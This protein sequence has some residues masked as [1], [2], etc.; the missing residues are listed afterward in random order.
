MRETK[1][2][3]LR[4][5]ETFD[6]VE[7]LRFPAAANDHVEIVG[8]G[9]SGSQQLEAGRCATPFDVIW[10]GAIAM[11][12]PSA[13]TTSIR[14]C[15]EPPRWVHQLCSHSHVRNGEA[16][17]LSRS[18]ASHSER[19]ALNPHD[20]SI[21]RLATSAASRR[22]AKLPPIDRARDHHAASR[23]G[24]IMLDPPRMRF[25]CRATCVMWRADRSW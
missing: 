14:S 21:T 11:S 4:P 12:S 7:T 19:N 2:R 25:T 18:S 8:A 20:E 1:R 5:D 9:L 24:R 13:R 3:V 15:D 17:A 22:G 16:D 10:N 6:R 23:V